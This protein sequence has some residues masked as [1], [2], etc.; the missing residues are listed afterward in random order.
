MLNGY[1]GHPHRK[2][3]LKGSLENSLHLLLER[4]A[5]GM[6]VEIRLLPPPKKADASPEEVERQAQ[7][8]Q[9]TE[10]AQSLDFPQIPPGHPMSQITRGEDD[11]DQTDQPAF[12]RP[13]AET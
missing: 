4:V 12:Q 2:N 10:I 8:D 3:E 7:F 1:T 13:L 6:T 9:L 11:G 5:N